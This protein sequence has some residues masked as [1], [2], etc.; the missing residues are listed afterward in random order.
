MLANISNFIRNL[1]I[2]ML[3]MTFVSAIVPTGKYKSYIN[4]IMGFML[5]FMM[6]SPIINIIGSFDDILIHIEEEI[7]HLEESINL[8]E[9]HIVQASVIT[10][11]ASYL[12]RTHIEEIVSEFGFIPVS[13]T[14]NMNMS[15]NDLQINNIFIEVTE[16]E[17]RGIP[18]I[19]NIILGEVIEEDS[20]MIEIKNYLAQFYNMPVNHINVVSN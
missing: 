4:L 7:S 17:I 19:N 3:F 14:I 20:R 1:A 18:P 5:I 11:N 6:V 13:T 8:D 12:V 10:E 2:F 9:A 16:E 15:G